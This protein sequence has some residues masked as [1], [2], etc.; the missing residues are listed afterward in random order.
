ME[1]VEHLS[2]RGA[3]DDHRRRVE[4]LFT[5]HYGELVGLAA[6]VTGDRTAG[7]DIVQ[8]VFAALYRRATPLDEPAA[9]VGYLRRS[10]VNGAR[11]RLRRRAVEVR[12]HPRIEVRVRSTEELVVADEDVVAVA[13]AVAALPIRQRECVACHYQLG[14]THLETADALAISASSVKT[15]LA[16]ATRRLATLLKDR[17]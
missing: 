2:D 6:L 7:E 13:A 16:R 11:D 15:H 1:I 4:V 8:D 3:I 17:R 5:A 14:L 12:V 10:V 9:V